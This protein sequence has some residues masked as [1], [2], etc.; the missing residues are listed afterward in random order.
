MRSSNVFRTAL[1]TIVYVAKYM[2]EMG[3]FAPLVCA[4]IAVSVFA[5]SVTN[6]YDWWV[7]STMRRRICAILYRATTEL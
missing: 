6:V 3:G 4:M 5:S 7:R 1:R 2:S